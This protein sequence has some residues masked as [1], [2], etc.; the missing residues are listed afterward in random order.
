MKILLLLVTAV[1]ATGCTTVRQA[2]TDFQNFQKT[3][4]FNAGRPAVYQN[5]YF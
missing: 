4:Q 5:A 1:L 2:K 3:I